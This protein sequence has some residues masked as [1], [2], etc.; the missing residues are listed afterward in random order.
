VLSLIQDP[1][2]KNEIAQIDSKAFLDAV[3][4]EPSE[5]V[6]WTYVLQRVVRQMVLA[7]VDLENIARTAPGGVGELK[8]AAGQIAST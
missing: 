2:F 5:D 3:A 8:Q 7:T 4:G 1:R 6:N